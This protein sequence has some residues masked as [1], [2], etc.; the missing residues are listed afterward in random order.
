M[1]IRML[2]SEPQRIDGR[3]VYFKAGQVYETPG[4][5]P[6]ELADRWLNAG[7][8]ELVPGESGTNVPISRGDS[9]TQEDEE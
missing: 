4:D 2:V 9:P 8:A 3:G 6:Q 1:K 7:L 5:L